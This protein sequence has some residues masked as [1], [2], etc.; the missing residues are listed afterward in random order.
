MKG[1]QYIYG[2]Q[3]NVTYRLTDW[4]AAAVGLRANYYDGY[5]KGH[6]TADLA[7]TMRLVNLLL[8]VDQKGWGFTP[9]VSLAFRQGP[10][11]LTARY[12]FRTKIETKND[13]NSLNAQ[14][15]SDSRD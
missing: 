6:V 8:D 13:T 1:K 14:L 7:A 12:E 3:L 5:Y 9:I 15:D 11:T 10:L 2:G 4:L